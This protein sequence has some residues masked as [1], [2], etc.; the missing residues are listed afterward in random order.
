MYEFVRTE[1]GWRVFWGVDPLAN[2]P[3]AD[4]LLTVAEGDGQ[5]E[6]LLA[7]LPARQPDDCPAGHSA[8]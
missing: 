4:G 7:V 5:A 2:N 3:Q 6:N 1:R 8:A